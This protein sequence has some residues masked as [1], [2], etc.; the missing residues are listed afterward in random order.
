M[1]G[2]EIEVAGQ[3]TDKLKLIAGYSYID[4]EIIEESSYDVLI[5]YMPEHMINIWSNY[6]VTDQLNMGVG[7]NALSK[8]E[9]P[10]G[11]DGK[12]YEVVNVMASYQFTPALQAQLNVN[13]LFNEHYYERVGD[14]GQFNIPGDERS[15]KATV[16]YQF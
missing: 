11:Q 1:K 6:Q 8:V 5:S 12:A 7:L 15:V 9:N 4:T 3:I 14:S 2:A 16:R 13:N 10:Y